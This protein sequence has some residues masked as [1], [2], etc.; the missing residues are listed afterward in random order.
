MVRIASD[1]CSR[2]ERCSSAR[3]RFI[4]HRTIGAKR[5]S[6]S[7]LNAASD[8]CT[9]SSYEI[10][11]GYN[12]ATEYCIGASAY[13]SGAKDQG[14]IRGLGLSLDVVGCASHYDQ[15]SQEG[16]ICSHMFHLNL[17]AY[18]LRLWRAGAGTAQS[19]PLQHNHIH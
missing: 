19:S 10:R 17:L 3:I 6:G 11:I 16:S 13:V 15:A 12:V 14:Y 2:A 8:R 1:R 7:G 18:E 4:A 9:S 5:N